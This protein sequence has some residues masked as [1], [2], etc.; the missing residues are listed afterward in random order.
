MLDKEEDEEEDEEKRCAGISLTC[1]KTLLR[2]SLAHHNAN[3]YDHSN[4]HSKRK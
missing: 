4:Y 1:I 3:K 2:N